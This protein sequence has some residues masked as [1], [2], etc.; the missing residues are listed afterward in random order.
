MMITEAQYNRL[1]SLY[2]KGSFIRVADKISEKRDG[3]YPSW[4]PSMNNMLGNEYQIMGLENIDRYIMA[5]GSFA[6]EP[7]V[8]VKSGSGNNYVLRLEWLDPQV[9]ERICKSPD[10]IDVDIKPKEQPNTNDENIVGTGFALLAS[11]ATLLGVAALKR[12]GSQSKAAEEKTESDDFE[13][14]VE[15]PVKSEV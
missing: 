2:P 9:I 12:K 4:I 11:A 14:T 10:P 13:I 8:V 7:L 1:L 15:E 3:L 5:D 6:Y